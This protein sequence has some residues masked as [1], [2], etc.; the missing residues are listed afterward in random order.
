M[1]TQCVAQ[2]RRAHRAIPFQGCGAGCSAQ[3]AKREDRTAMGIDALGRGQHARFGRDAAAFEFAEVRSCLAAGLGN[4]HEVA[5]QREQ[6]AHE[7]VGVHVVVAAVVERV[8]RPGLAPAP[9]RH[10]ARASRHGRLPPA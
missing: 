10:A 4:A 9:V 2:L 1:P 6:A 3:Q 7:G 5:A 8:T